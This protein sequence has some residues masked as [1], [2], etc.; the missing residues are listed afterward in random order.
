MRILIVLVVGLGVAAG[1]SLADEFEGW[2]RTEIVRGQQKAD[3]FLRFGVDADGAPVSHMGVPILRMYEV[4]VGTYAAT[5]STLSLPGLSWELSITEDGT[6]LEGFMPASLVGDQE[7]AA[8]FERADA[9]EPP[10]FVGA[11]EPPA[12]AWTTHVGAE[13]WAGL[14]YD[15]SRGL[16]Y[17]G[18]DDG[19]V[20][21]FHGR[22]GEVNWS[23]DLGAPIRATPTL[24]DGWLYIA[25]DKALH[26]LEA[27]TGKEAWSA[28]F[29]EPLQ[30]RLATTE[31]KARW[32]HYSSSAVV[33]G[34]LIVVGA[35]DGCIHALERTSGAQ[36]WD[37]CTEDIVTS[38]PAITEHAVFFGGFDGSAYALSRKD[39]SEL[40]RHDAGAPIPRDAILTGDGVVL[41]GS[42]S[43][44]LIALESTT[45][46]LAWKHYFW[47]SWVDSLPVLRDG[48]IY[49]GGSDLLAVLAL[50]AATGTE[51]WSSPT[52][53]E[54]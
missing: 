5:D 47:S 40:W 42:R 46:E 15:P 26:A 32:D 44:Y 24:Y 2:W 25:T 23:K 28:A 31:P 29:G 11:S 22:T 20:W 53:G 12:T 4:P 37:A 6:V 50:D 3:F 34:D 30:P 45:G 52:P 38:T 33:D 27:R 54:I 36:R 43:S 7:T 16:L 48:V 39:G 8:R 9:P 21:A 14:V 13:V 41:F 10:V 35:R 17:L 49:V 1:A 18:A 51:L 19:R